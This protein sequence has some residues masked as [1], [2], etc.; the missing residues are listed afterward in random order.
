MRQSDGN[1]VKHYA[2]CIGWTREQIARRLGVQKATLQ[3]W[4][5]GENRPPLLAVR[6][7]AVWAGISSPYEA[8]ILIT[9]WKPGAPEQP[10][11]WWALVQGKQKPVPRYCWYSDDMQLLIN[12]PE[13][14]PLAIARVSE[15]G[16]EIVR[17]HRMIAPPPPHEP[18]LEEVA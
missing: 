13:R 3:K 8:E 14:G 6:Q 5:A 16:G 15:V 2:N 1:A 12:V 9:N 4:I 17:H 18:A 11:W 7:L 10:G